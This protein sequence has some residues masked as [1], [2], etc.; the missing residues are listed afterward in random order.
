MTCSQRAPSG[1][2]LWPLVAACSPML[3]GP[4]AESCSVLTGCRCRPCGAGPL[5]AGQHDDLAK[6]LL[7]VRKK[8]KDPKV[9]GVRA[10]RVAR[11]P[12]GRDREVHM[13]HP[14]LLHAPPASVR[15]RPRL[16]ACPRASRLVTRLR[17]PRLADPALR[18]LRRR[19]CRRWTPSWCTPTP[20][21]RTSAR[22]RSS[23]PAAT[24]RTCRRWETGGRR[25]HTR[26]GG[27]A[28]AAQGKQE[29]GGWPAQPASV[30]SVPPLRSAPSLAWRALSLVLS[31][32]PDVPSPAPQVLRG[33]PVRCSAHHL[34]AHP[35]LRPPGLHA[36]APAPVPGS[37]GRCAQGAWRRPVGRCA[38]SRASLP[39]A[40][41][42]RHAAADT[43]RGEA[44]HDWAS[45]LAP[46]PSLPCRPT[47]LARGR[48]WRTRAWRRESSS[49]HSSA[50]ST[51]LS[52]PTT[53]WRCA[54]LALRGTPPESSNLC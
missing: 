18:V 25:G 1:R 2:S 33:G 24:W 5:Q 30:P 10:D 16:P 46:P 34:H 49:S 13:Q 21:T 32:A 4:L 54:A 27:H 17:C 48:R 9:R 38:A 47:R 23:L 15:G 6:Y 31:A 42:G 29:V 22:W 41:S 3:P 26:A 36:R 45:D 53:S 11:Q 19:R 8:V 37:G 51:S 50:A 14:H 43:T 44:Q 52:T 35:Q 39:P 12:G 20:R 28:A 7:M 40:C